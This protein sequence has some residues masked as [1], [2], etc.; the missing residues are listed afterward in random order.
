MLKH[1]LG[2]LF[3]NS[4]KHK[5][6]L[7]IPNSKPPKGSYNNLKAI[8]E[9]KQKGSKKFWKILYKMKHVLKTAHLWQE[10]LGD[11]T[12]TQCIVLKGISNFPIVKS[13]PLGSM[14]RKYA[15]FKKRKSLKEINQTLQQY[16]KLVL[17]M[18]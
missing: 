2:K 6:P 14:V 8:F 1:H 4:S 3:G 15:S 12:I 13:Y 10:T 16:T 7:P 9:R 5:Y 17:Y 18:V 11:K